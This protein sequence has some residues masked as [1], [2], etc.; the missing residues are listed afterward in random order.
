[1]SRTTALFICLLLAIAFVLGLMTG[2]TRGSGIVIDSPMK[3][4]PPDTRF[5]RSYYELLKELKIEKII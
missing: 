1:M 3:N 4:S 2:C 5:G